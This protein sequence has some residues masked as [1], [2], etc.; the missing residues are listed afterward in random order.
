[1][2][3][4][5][6]KKEKK[7]KKKKEHQIIHLQEAFQLLLQSILVLFFLIHSDGQIAMYSN[8]RGQRS[9]REL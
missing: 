6:R 1:M 8:K 7:E 3:K 4:K 2:Y 9:K 5:K